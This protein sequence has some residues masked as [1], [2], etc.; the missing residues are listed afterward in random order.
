MFVSYSIYFKRNCFPNL[1]QIT[2]KIKL[3]LLL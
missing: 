1:L 2:N 3:K